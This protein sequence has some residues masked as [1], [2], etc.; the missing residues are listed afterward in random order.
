M[1][2]R[3]SSSARRWTLAEYRPSFWVNTSL[4]IICALYPLSFGYAVV[5]H[6][7]MEIP[8]L[9]RRSARYFLVQRGFTVLLFVVAFSAIAFFSHAL[10]RFSSPNTSAGMMF[11]AAFGTLRWFGPRRH[12]ELKRGTQR[13]DRAF[14]RRYAYDARLILQDLAE[15]ARTVTSRGELAELLQHHLEKALR[16]KTFVCYLATGD[17]R[18]DHGV[19]KKFR[20][21]RRRSPLVR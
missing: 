4:I 21:K 3:L 9:L 13:I 19:Q 8:V 12:Y 17:S 11:S 6:R 10:S 16:P 7:V 15:R 18:A 20:R 1:C 2:C 5:K 14:F